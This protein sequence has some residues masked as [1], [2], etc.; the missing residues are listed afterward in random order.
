MVPTARHPIRCRCTISA[1]VL[2]LIAI[3]FSLFLRQCRIGTSPAWTDT[4]TAPHRRH[5]YGLRCA[6]TGTSGEMGISGGFPENCPLRPE[7]F[8]P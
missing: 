5:R 2:S 7:A 8:F 4:I 6:V 3:H 1:R